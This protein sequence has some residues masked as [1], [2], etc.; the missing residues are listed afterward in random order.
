MKELKK[1]IKKLETERN[2]LL[3][4]LKAKGLELLRMENTLMLEALTCIAD[5]MRPYSPADLRDKARTALKE[6]AE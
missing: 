3:I 6:L 4:Q 5:D 1:E 2:A